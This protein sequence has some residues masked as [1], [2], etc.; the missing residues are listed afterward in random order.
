MTKEP[1]DQ[2]FASKPPQRGAV[3]GQ[4]RQPTREPLR[5]GRGGQIHVGHNGEQLT[6][7]RKSG[8]DPFEF[9]QTFVP[10]GWEYQWCAVSS[11]G[12]AE[13]M[14]TQNLEF[15]QNGWRPVPAER[16]D[17]FFLQRGHKGEIVVR[18]Q[19]LMERPKAMCDEAR[20][21]E[22][23]VAVR[24]MRDRNEALMGGKAN[25][26]GATAAQGI[27]V[28]GTGDRS[29]TAVRMAI[30]PALDI[31]MPAHTLAEPGE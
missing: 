14:R 4:M 31:E 11:Y 12:N 21:E 9:P 7:S 8:V 19:L 25:L 15:Y 30:D 5:D 24:Q 29:G 26:G 2:M 10:E 27:P 6:R 20:A 28:R 3:R 23:A 18:G 13:I 1:D 17:G 16:H 22:K